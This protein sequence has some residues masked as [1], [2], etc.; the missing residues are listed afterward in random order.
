[1]THLYAFSP[2]VSPTAPHAPVAVTRCGLQRPFVAGK[3]PPDVL[4]HLGG[5]T[6]P[7]CLR[8]ASGKADIAQQGKKAQ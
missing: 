8:I 7:E 2:Y 3:I 1:M 4:D 6:C 5:V